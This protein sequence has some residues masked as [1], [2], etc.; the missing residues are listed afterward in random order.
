VSRGL[1]L[2]LGGEHAAAER[3]FEHAIRLNPQFFE[4]FYFYA[5]DAFAQGQ[6][7]KAIGLYEQAMALRPDDYQAPLLVA[8]L[9]ADLG[10]A[11][12]AE[13]ARR[14]GLKV[15]EEH[16][17]HRPD[18]VRALYMAANAMVAMGE[19]ERGLEWARRALALD[20]DDPM[21]LY[22]VA[23]I[24]AMAGDVEGALDCLEKAA[25]TGLIQ[26]DWVVH[27]SNLD[28]VRGHPRYEALLRD[29]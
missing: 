5:R 20:P 29:A 8:Q 21:I 10:R 16:L 24:R 26:I 19:R 22:N 17:G 4:A 11:A 2:S 13:V 14:R 3:E 7:E 9:Y 15:A 1:A 12:D 23:C 18:D 6:A 27:D 25:R 28:A